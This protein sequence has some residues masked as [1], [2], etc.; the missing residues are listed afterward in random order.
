MFLADTGVEDQSASRRCG[1]KREAEKNDK[2]EEGDKNLRSRI[3]PRGKGLAPRPPGFV[4]P[5][6]LPEKDA[7]RTL[8]TTGKAQGPQKKDKEAAGNQNKAIK[9]FLLQ[10]EARLRIIERATSKTTR[11]KSRHSAKES[12]KETGEMY[13]KEVKN[14]Q[15]EMGSKH[16]HYALGLMDFLAGEKTEKE[17]NDEQRDK[18][19]TKSATSLR[20]AR[21]AQVETADNKEDW[22]PDFQ[23]HKKKTEVT[24]RISFAAVGSVRV[25]NAPK[26]S[27]E[28]FHSHLRVVK[29]AGPDKTG[30]IEY[31]FV[32]L[33]LRRTAVRF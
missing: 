28:K 22:E 12:L 29:K 11:M 5:S 31:Q 25:K 23:K 20:E 13:N 15:G 16:F 24:S 18:A 27:G 1:R 21:A 26:H 10:L 33:L 17:K 4:R 14:N 2:Q 7:N 19:E 3:T 32:L 30:R 9:A 6:P 8:R